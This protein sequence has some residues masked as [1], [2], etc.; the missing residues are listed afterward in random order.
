MIPAPELSRTREQRRVFVATAIG[1]MTEWYD[2]F[3]YA[4]AS[5][6]IFAT[7]FFA[8]AGPGF[9]TIVAFLTLGLSYLFRPLGAFIA[10]HLGDKI[11]R[12]KMLVWTLLT[13]GIAT[14]LI[15]FVPTYGTI[16]ISA[17]IILILLRI[18]QGLSAGGEW[19][20]AVLMSV[21]HAP[22]ARRGALGVAPQIGVPLGLLTSSGVMAIMTMIAP[23]EAF[24]EWGWRVPFLLSIVLVG[25]GYY[26]RLRLEESPVFTRLEQEGER[27]RVPVVQL[28]RRH[29]WLVLVASLIFAGS[30]GVGTMTTGGFV[31]NYTTD[32]TGPIHLDR[33]PILWAVALGSL[34]W[35]LSTWVSGVVSDRFGRKRVYVF[36]WLAQLVGVVA[37]FPLVNLGTVWSTLLGLVILSV[38]IGITYGP[39]SVVYAELFPA[40]IRYSGVAITYAIGAVLGG[41]FGPV[42]ASTLVKTTGGTAAVTVY[43]VVLTLVGLAATLVLHDRTGVALDGH[44][45]QDETPWMF[46]RSKAPA[47]PAG[48]DPVV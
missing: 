30:T 9:A 24:V 48:S 35:L 33:E 25:V 18:L 47:I 31:Q 38:G 43:L 40:P 17:P 3:T 10:G 19:G 34:C 7:E 45:T 12:R 4:S 6:L 5:A 29:G 32:P 42:I 36:G 26:A 14:T 1:T 20:G 15:G 28:F 39:L 27:V 41:A 46:A 23:G 37:L 2:F 21:E 11:G 13:M 8:P 22:A 44:A 16:G